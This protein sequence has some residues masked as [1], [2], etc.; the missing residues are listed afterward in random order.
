VDYDTCKE[1]CLRQTEGVV[2]LNEK[3]ATWPQESYEEKGQVL[4][5]R[6]RGTFSL[7][8]TV[9]KGRPHIKGLQRV[10]V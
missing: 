10:H 1:S 6:G 5:R 8:G 9:L 2:L 7:G 3:Q 4:P